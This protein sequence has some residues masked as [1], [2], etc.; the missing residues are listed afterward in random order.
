MEINDALLQL[1]GVGKWQ[2][3][4]FLAL[5]GMN[6]INCFHTMAIVFIG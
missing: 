5:A 3:K 4:N 6:I 1:G 2:V